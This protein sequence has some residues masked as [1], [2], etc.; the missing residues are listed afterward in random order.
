M[1][2]PRALRFYAT[3][4]VVALLGAF[5]QSTVTGRQIAGPLVNSYIVNHTLAAVIF[6]FLFRWRQ[7]HIEKLGFLFMAGTGLKFLTFF[8]VFYPSFRADGELAQAEFL[9][10][11]I[12]YALSTLVET[13]FLARILNR[14]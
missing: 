7:R 4:L 10:F 14:E 6:T 9:L 8:I 13:V 11:F 3:L 1:T 2:D 5:V 12:P